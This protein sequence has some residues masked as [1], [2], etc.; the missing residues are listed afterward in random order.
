ME[1]GKAK[2]EWQQTARLEA[3]MTNLCQIEIAANSEKKQK[4][5]PKDWTDFYPFDPPKQKPIVEKGSINF[6]KAFVDGRIQPKDTS[7]R[8][9]HQSNGG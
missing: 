3:V 1:D 7:G 5:R 9:L 4:F 6:L 2:I 8:R